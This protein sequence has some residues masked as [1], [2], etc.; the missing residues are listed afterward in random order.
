MSIANGPG[1]KRGEEIPPLDRTAYMPTD[2]NAVNVIHTDDYAK[3]MGLRGA[4]IGGSMLLSYI[5][6]MLFGYFGENWYRYGRIKVSYV[7]GGA[8]N[9]DVLT[10]HGLV[11]DIQPETDGM[12]YHLDVWVE[13]QLGERIAVGKASCVPQQSPLHDGSGTGNGR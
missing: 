5:L 1:I 12:R 11:Q 7:G 6:E 10:A 8:V 2:P 3:K 9:G 13:N 4:L